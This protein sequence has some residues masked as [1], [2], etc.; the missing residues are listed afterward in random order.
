MGSKNLKAFQPAGAAGAG[1]KT[2]F[3]ALWEQNMA[4]R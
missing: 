3:M 1:D 2:A 4:E